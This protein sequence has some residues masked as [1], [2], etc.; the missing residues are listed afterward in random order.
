MKKRERIGLISLVLLLLAVARASGQT[1]PTHGIV[2]LQK[3]RPGQ[4]I[5]RVW[6]DPDA[7]GKPFVAR[8]HA[9]AGYIVLP[10]THPIDENIVV[11]QGEWE[12]AMGSRFDRSILESIGVGGFAFGPKD[13]PHFA[14]SKTDST[15]QVHGVG[16]F[17]VKLVD[18]AYDLT[19]KGILLLD[20]LLR[21]GTPVDTAP[22]DCFSFKFGERV[23]GKNGN[24]RVIGARCSPANRL[25][26]YWIR[27][28]DGQQYWAISEDLRANKTKR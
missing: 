7:V 5:E 22:A 19:E 11:I 26:Q 12:F 28:D 10:H 9:D 18:P 4:W 21:P 6:G 1:T 14:L 25:T 24:G 17:S 3:P 27:R 16:P 13:M 23:H 2:Q 8:I 20:Y 15:I